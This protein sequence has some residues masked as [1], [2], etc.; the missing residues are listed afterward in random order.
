MKR[1]LLAT[2]AFAAVNTAYAGEGGHKGHTQSTNGHG[3]GFPT[4]QDAFTFARDG[5]ILTK[6]LLVYTVTNGANKVW[7]IVP[8]E[9]RSV[10]TGQISE[11]DGTVDAMRA[12]NGL[13]DPMALYGQGK[14]KVH[15][16]SDLV[17]H[18]LFDFEADGFGIYKALNQAGNIYE[19]VA[20]K[21]VK[22]F[23]GNL[24]ADFEEAYPQHRERFE[25]T[26]KVVASSNPLDLVFF[27]VVF[28]Y[29]A[30]YVIGV[31]QWIFSFLVCDIFFCGLCCGSRA[32]GKKAV[33]TSQV[34]P[35][36]QKKKNK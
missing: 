20:G 17:Y 7:N 21:H 25:I 24:L 26:N 2:A 31:F 30:Y 8:A 16:L 1:I 32:G 5:T 13:P 9:Q 34:S 35:K 36:L 15:H 3:N 33:R 28:F 4:I 14:S 12:A 18:G 6:D 11:V 23:A 29:A 22:N 10:I 19:D 27:L